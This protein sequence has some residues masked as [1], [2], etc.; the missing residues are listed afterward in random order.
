MVRS[1][2][3][4]DESFRNV[5]AIEQLA[6][7]VKLMAAYDQQEGRI[8]RSISDGWLRHD[9]GFFADA[10]VPQALIAAVNRGKQCGEF[11]ST[12]DAHVAAEV[13]YDC[14]LQ[15]LNRWLHSETP[16]S[17]ERALEAK[18]EVLVHGLQ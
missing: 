5:A 12:I 3:L 16:F 18:L 1:I 17:L 2:L 9:S 11:A 7:L 4:Q 14:Y 6:G 8:A 13:I 15:T 10:V